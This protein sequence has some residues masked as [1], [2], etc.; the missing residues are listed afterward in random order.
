MFLS[1][2]DDPAYVLKSKSCLPYYDPDQLA[3]ASNMLKEEL[4]ELLQSTGVTKKDDAA[5]WEAA[6][7]EFVY[8][9]QRA[10]YCSQSKVGT[11]N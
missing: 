2:A 5:L 11:A 3:V 4:V 9:S 10:E 6:I 8:V 7:E 1:Q